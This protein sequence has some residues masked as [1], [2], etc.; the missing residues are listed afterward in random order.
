MA[1]LTEQESLE[2]VYSSL[3][4]VWN[5]AHPPSDP[6]F[7]QDRIVWSDILQLPPVT[8]TWLYYQTLVAAYVLDP[9]HYR[10]G[11]NQKKYFAHLDSTSDESVQQYATFLRN[12]IVI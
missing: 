9:I 6:S 11:M 10:P 3:I 1:A 12:E 2:V 8:K 5:F 7:P 4:T